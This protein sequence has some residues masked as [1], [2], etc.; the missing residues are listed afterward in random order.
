[1]Q[2]SH[3]SVDPGKPCSLAG[4]AS[5]KPTQTTSQATHS[6][7][8]ATS[9]PANAC[10]VAQAAAESFLSA[11]PSATAAAIKPSVAY[12]CL[13]TLEPL[14]NP[15][16]GYLAPG[17]DVI[18][19]LGQIRA[20]V[21]KDKY[22]S[23]IEFA[24][25]I[26]RLFTQAS[27]GHFN[28]NPALLSLF[29]F[30]SLNNLVSVS[31]DG[32]SVPRVYLISDFL[33]SYVNDTDV[34]DIKSIDDV[35]ITEWLEAQSSRVFT[36]DPDAK[37]NSLFNTNPATE[38][39]G[40]GNEFVLRFPGHCPD[41]QVIKFTNGTE[42]VDQL[43]AVVSESFVE[44]LSSA[45][46]I[47][48][49]VELP[50]TGTSSVASSSSATSSSAYSATPTTTQI[51]G[52]PYPVSKHANIDTAN[53]TFE[54]GEAKRVVD[55]FLKKA[56]AAS[57]KKLVI[58]LQANG[59]GFVAAGF[60]LYNQLFPE[61][62]DIWDGNRIRAHEAFNAIGLT[63]QEASPDVLANLVSNVLNDKLKPFKDWEYLFGPEV[64]AGQ[65]VTN[66]LRYNQTGLGYPKS[67]ED[68]VFQPGNIIVI[69]DGICASTCTIFT[70]LL[71]REQGVR[72]IA[73]GGRP[74]EAPMQAI[75]GVE[76]SEVLDWP[77]LQAAIMQVASDAIAA[78]ETDILEAAFDVLPDLGDPPL[79]PTLA[80]SGGSFNYRNAYARKRPDSFPEQFIYEA[81]NCRLFY[82]ADMLANITEIWARSAD[83]AWNK[84]KC[85]GGSTVCKDGIISN[86]ILPF[87]DKVVGMHLEYKGPGSLSYKG[88]Y[89]P[90]SPYVQKHTNNKRSIVEKLN[91]PENLVYE[92]TKHKIGDLKEYV[93]QN[94]P[95]DFKYE[96]K[97]KIGISH[98]HLNRE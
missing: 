94:M 58:D 36:Q 46:A 14:A 15:P 83:S 63:A 78:N 50:P 16:E 49:K 10:A 28:Y 79:L 24:L 88:A 75:G 22:K 66:L 91:V 43:V 35:P 25:D 48:S 54:I 23:Q 89:E 38:F 68:Q 27:D 45:E 12:D 65:N 90:P 17:V 80:K 34:Y 64:I 72:T 73:L 32:L 56:K 11:R 85:V 6:G 96:Q 92:P 47:H 74:S 31:D 18:G 13:N 40:V 37:Y 3:L 5:A 39:Q 52:Y 51:P 69:T 19:G 77:S 44:Y 20:R 70:G 53:G 26:K 4:A 2:T 29:T 97:H 30:R 42:Y 81:A 41:K 59:G 57:K 84:A 8:H 33:K 98:T 87:S 61:T 9:T 1:M 71:V 86:D 21:M 76:G 7:H 95:E 82:T 93:A 67:T 55:V 60:Q 62:T